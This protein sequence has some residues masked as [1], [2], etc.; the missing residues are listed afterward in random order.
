MVSSNGQ[1][2]DSIG[3]NVRVDEPELEGLSL[4]LSSTFIPLQE[5]PCQPSLNYC[6]LPTVSLPGSECCR[7]PWMGDCHLDGWIDRLTEAL[8]LDVDVTI[9]GHGPP[10]DKSEVLR[11]RSLFVALRREVGAAIRAGFSEEA[12]MQSIELP[13]FAHLPRYEQW[14]AINIKSAYR[15]LKGQ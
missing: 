6:Q 13:E 1:C 12:A 7:F 14:R 15:Y 3:W 5:P 11:F 2:R 8:S 10:T 9:P 4:Y